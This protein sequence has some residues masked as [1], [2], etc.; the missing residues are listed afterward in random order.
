MPQAAK[1]AKLARVHLCD[2]EPIFQPISL[3]KP[4]GD[5]CAAPSLDH[6]D[7][8]YHFDAHWCPIGQNGVPFGVRSCPYASGPSDCGIIPCLRLSWYPLFRGKISKRLGVN[9]GPSSTLQLEQGAH[10][11]EVPLGQGFAHRGE[12]AVDHLR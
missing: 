9:P 12:R 7:A 3:R 1:T 2:L 5:P 10:G 4:R 6:N 8:G 11:G